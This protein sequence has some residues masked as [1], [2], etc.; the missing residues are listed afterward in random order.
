MH[1]WKSRDGGIGNAE[2]NVQGRAGR[3]FPTKFALWT[4]TDK[5]D[6]AL[7]GMSECVNKTQWEKVD[8]TYRLGAFDTVDGRPSFVASQAPQPTTPI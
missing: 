1:A 5:A 6:E 3:S 4:V 8:T 2:R 7:R